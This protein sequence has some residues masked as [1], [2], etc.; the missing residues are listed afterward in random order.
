MQLGQLPGS[1]GLCDEING[2]LVR[3]RSTD[4]VGQ[5]RERE[6]RR[7]DLVL[8]GGA[9]GGLWF[10]E[11]AKLCHERTRLVCLEGGR[12]ERGGADCS[13]GSVSTLHV[14]DG[15]LICIYMGTRWLVDMEDSGLTSWRRPR[16]TGQLRQ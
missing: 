1:A 15:I 2:E 10:G 6:R 11:G 5:I 13:K 8:G 16:V 3:G 7:G 9:L 14:P 4:E 12:W